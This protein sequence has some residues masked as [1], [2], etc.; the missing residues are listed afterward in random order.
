MKHRILLVFAVVVL[1]I[2]GGVAI[3]RFLG[4]GRSTEVSAAGTVEVREV[5]V[6]ARNSSM[7]D[8][9]IRRSILFPAGISVA[10]R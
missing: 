8:G 6:T 7:P 2:A 1:A 5:S 10:A 3:C 9:S 4:N